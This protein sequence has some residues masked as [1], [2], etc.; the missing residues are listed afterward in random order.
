MHPRI[1]TI[2]REVLSFG[3]IALVLL[4]ARSTLADHY[5]VP[6]GSME[7]TL[8]PGDR[9]FVAK[10]TYGFRLPFTDWKLTRGSDVERGEVVVFDSPVEDIRLVKRI[11]A[12]GGDTVS[13]RSGQVSI[14]GHPMGSATDMREEFYGE[15]RVRL[16]LTYS[17]GEDFGPE[18]IPPGYL[19]AIGDAR[20]NSKDGRTFGFISGDA[21]YGR[22]VA[23]YYRS[24]EGLCWLKL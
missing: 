14:N 7:Y 18:V 21:V 20:G 5:T 12:V 23:V 2:G 4:A 11:V 13:I 17:G 19:L 6:S 9:I 24:G 10:Y 1:K 22:A 16:N 15:R 3:L 8:M